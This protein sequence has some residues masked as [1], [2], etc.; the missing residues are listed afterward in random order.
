MICNFS[1]DCFYF[2]FY[3]VRQKIVGSFIGS[4]AKEFGSGIIEGLEKSP[5]HGSLTKEKT[6]PI[7]DFLK[8]QTQLRSN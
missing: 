8:K 1:F 6:S 4:R 2:T 5:K 7:K 3:I